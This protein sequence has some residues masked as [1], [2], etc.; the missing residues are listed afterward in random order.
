M[1]NKIKNVFRLAADN[2]A[3]I[4]T[5]FLA[6]YLV[7]LILSW[8]FVAWQNY[9]Y[10]PAFHFVLVILFII[11]LFSKRW[12]MA[13]FKLIEVAAVKARVL[14]IIQS[15]IIFFLKL[16]AKDYIKLVVIIIIIGASLFYGLEPIDSV[17]LFFGLFFLFFTVNIRFGVGLALLFLLLCPIFLVLEKD[18]LVEWLV[19]RAYY[20][21][22]V[23]V[24]MK[25]KNLVFE[26][27]SKLSTGKLK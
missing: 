23:A 2:V 25:I 3:A 24:L 8:F 19:V 12:R 9:F 26:W 7:C 1:A 14:L 18:G 5:Y 13:G 6:F 4:F 11:S 20:F 27:R 17:I 22:I 21:L 16:T 10:W 15:V